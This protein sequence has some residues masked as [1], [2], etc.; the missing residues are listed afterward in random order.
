MPKMSNSFE[1]VVSEKEGGKYVPRGK[2]AVFYPTLADLNVINATVKE[3]SEDGFPIYSDDL[4]Q[5]MFD[6]CLAS[7]KAAARNKLEV[8]SGVVRLKDGLAIAETTEQLLESGGGNNG[9][10]LQAI[11]DFLAAAKAWLATTGKSSGVQA[12]VLA[13]WTRVDTIA[14]IED[15]AKKEKIQQYLALF[16]E[17]ITVEQATAW[18]RRIEAIDAMCSS[19]DNALDSADF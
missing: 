3:T 5:W 8:V 2:V 7:T 6:S 1:M 13:F 12:A 18:Q 10:A 4:H 15:R 11:R 19:A 16:V 14:L 9:A 17:T